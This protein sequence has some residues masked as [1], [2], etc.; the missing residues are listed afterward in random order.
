MPVYL[1][2]IAIDLVDPKR[3]GPYSKGLRPMLRRRHSPIFGR[4][5]SINH[6]DDNIPSWDL[7]SD[8]DGDYDVGQSSDSDSDSEAG[9][10]V[11]ENIQRRPS[12]VTRSAS[13]RSRRRTPFSA[14]QLLDK[15]KKKYKKIIVYK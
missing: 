4:R 11:L 9:S 10:S 2:N 13:L 6:H 7:N 14:A 3:L 12:P 8:S 5:S 15:F 1:R